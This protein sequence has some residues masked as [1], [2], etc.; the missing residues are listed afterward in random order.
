M[1]LGCA[2]MPPRLAPVGH[3]SKVILI[4]FDALTGDTVERLSAEHAFSNDGFE[5]MRRE[6]TFARVVPVTPTQTSV[7]HV[8][9]ITGALPRVTG[10]L[11]NNFHHQGAPVTQ[12]ASGFSMPIGA[13]T[14]V[15]AA[16]RQ[17]KRVGVLAFPS[18]DATNDRRQ[19][20]WGLVYTRPV[21]KGSLVHLTRKDFV[22]A[23]D[24][25]PCRA[26]FSPP[27]R[28][29]IPWVL[30]VRGQGTSRDVDLWA[31]DS[32][33][34]GTVNY[35]DT[36]VR[37]GDEDIPLDPQHW[38]P[39]S[40]RIEE[41]G[42]SR[43]YGSWSKL[44]RLDPR[45]ERVAVY[46]GS[47]SRND[48]YPAELTRAVDAAAGF[49]PGPP[50]LDAAKV[51]LATG[52]GLDPESFVEQ[53]D[54][55]AAFHSASTIAAMKTET[56]DLLLL[57]ESIVDESQH[58]FLLTAPDQEYSTPSNRAAAAHVVRD[59]FA[60]ADRGV[61]TILAAVPPGTAMIV[62]GD[63]GMAPAV[64]D[65]RLNQL[66]IDWGLAQASKGALGPDSRWGA[67]G[68]GENVQLYRFAGTDDSAALID[69]LQR[70]QGPDGTAVF[71][72]VER[73]TSAD[74]PDA[75]DLLAYTHTRYVINM[76]LG[77]PFVKLVTYGQ[78]GGL[79]LHHELHTAVFAVGPGVAHAHPA[80]VQQTK[81]ARYIAEL[82]GIEAPRNAE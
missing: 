6:G 30:A 40:A 31:C 7:T 33:D 41:G 12:V 34:D 47:I 78:H 77:D 62:T 24:A 46:F 4:S 18:F 76:T 71:E 15:E 25:G 26:S 5:K 17:G 27:L 38:F 10:I 63:H 50:D 59:A 36:R 61:A 14:I 8:S 80:P 49:N 72:R 2:T 28:A 16:R 22:A 64:Y 13:E 1:L 9:M 57:Y 69:R 54:R 70:L 68:S 75:G 11:G 79:N 52:D 74:H 21:T 3:A 55:L 66:L 37:I 73:R 32:T 19:G 35:D 56:F 67:Y 23:P 39:I 48:G 42:E 43:L 81:L 60:A 58:Q 65:V 45:L 20:D 51:W 82:L 53:V 29:R 44:L